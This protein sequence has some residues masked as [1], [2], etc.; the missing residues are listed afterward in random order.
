[1]EAMINMK[2]LFKKY[3]IEYVDKDG[4]H[5]LF[6]NSMSEIKNLYK[7]YSS[8]FI[9]HWYVFNVGYIGFVNDNGEII[10]E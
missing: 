1:M 10:K 2:E 3:M 5:F 7:E 9:Y 4:T 8:N 6:A